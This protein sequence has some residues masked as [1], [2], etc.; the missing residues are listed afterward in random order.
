M[1]FYNFPIPI[2]PPIYLSSSLRAKC[3]IDVCTLNTAPRVGD[4]YMPVEMPPGGCLSK[5][6][7]GASRGNKI[8]DFR[9]QMLHLKFQIMHLKVQMMDLNFRSY[10][11][12]FR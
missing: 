5:A 12:D 2:F 9:F 4:L 6:K 1:Y 8:S 3:T 7:F 11:W 10:T